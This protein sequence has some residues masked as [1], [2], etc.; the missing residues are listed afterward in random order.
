MPGTHELPEDLVPLTRRNAFELHDTS[1]SDDIRRL[2]TVLERVVGHRDDGEVHDE[3]RS[4]ELPSP[5]RDP[6]AGAPPGAQREARFA[7]RPRWRQVILAV[8]LAG[9]ITVVP[10]VPWY[11]LTGTLTPGLINWVIFHPITLLCGLWVSLAWPGSHPRAYVLLGSCAAL[12][13]LT[14]NLGF[15][16][17]ISFWPSVDL[18]DLLSDI[19]I[20][21]LFTVGGHFGDRYTG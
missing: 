10:Q 5:L 2:V 9:T 7:P 17:L 6:R 1:W 14:I 18:A 8:L 21:A 16:R 13:D 15:E 11:V 12:L 4:G 20:V 3:R 19:G